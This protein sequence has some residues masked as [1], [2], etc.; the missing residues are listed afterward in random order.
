MKI[1]KGIFQDDRLSPLLFVLA[2]IPLSFVLGDEKAGYALS[3]QRK[4]KKSQ[5][6]TIHKRLK[7]LCSKRESAIATLVNTVQV[8]F[9]SQGI[10][11][12]FGIRKCGVLGMKKEKYEYSESCIYPRKMKFRKWIEGKGTRIWGC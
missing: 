3:S 1:N 7:T 8:F 6:F 2:L 11:M 5:A 10:G 4:E 12:E 9:N